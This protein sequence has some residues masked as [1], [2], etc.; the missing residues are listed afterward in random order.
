MGY[1]ALIGVLGDFSRVCFVEEKLGCS[2]INAMGGF[3]DFIGDCELKDFPLSNVQFTLSVNC[4]RVVSSWLDRFLVTIVW[5]D[6]FLDLIPEIL[7]FLVSDYFPILLESRRLK[8][9]P[10]LLDLIICSFSTAL[11]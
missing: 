4:G 7:S 10:T 11:S 8:K 2:T 1:V 5:E 6:F 9:G 3:D